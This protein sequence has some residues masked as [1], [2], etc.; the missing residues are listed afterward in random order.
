M[1][2]E[3]KFE[4]L[5]DDVD[6]RKHFFYEMLLHDVYLLANS[7]TGNTKI[8]TGENLQVFSMIYE[9]L[10]FVPI[11]LSLDSLSNFLNEQS[12]PYVKANAADLLETLKERDVV[13]NP[14]SDHALLLFSP[15]IIDLLKKSLN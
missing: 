13:I 2:L 12:S 1:T 10:E 14:G 9:G 4:L 5:G 15:E 11:F 3:E 6:K 7:T 8:E